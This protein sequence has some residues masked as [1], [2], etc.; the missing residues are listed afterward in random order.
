MKDCPSKLGGSEA[1]DQVKMYFRV[2]KDARWEKKK[3]DE[4]AA[5][6]A[7]EAKAAAEAEDIS[8]A[9][10]QIYCLRK[11]KLQRKFQ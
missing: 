8:A 11:P 4:A 5:E 7:A 9:V 10:C 2:S 6:A 3:A 1:E